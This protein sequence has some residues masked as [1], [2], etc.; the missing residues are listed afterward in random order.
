PF[1]A[2][3]DGASIG[4]FAGAWQTWAWG[5]LVGALGFALLLALTGGRAIAA[6]LDAWRRVMAVRERTFVGVMA[7]LLAALSVGATLA[8]FAGNPR[9]VDGFAQL[10]QARIFL[11]GRLWM[12][13]PGD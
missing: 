7:A 11:A 5:S 4:Y 12:P 3:W 8:V 1:A 10:F 13:P 2:W 9:N 6:L